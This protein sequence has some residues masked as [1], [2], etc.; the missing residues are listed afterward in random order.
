MYG[1]DWYIIFEMLYTCDYVTIA[2]GY[3]WAVL[4][5]NNL[6]TKILLTL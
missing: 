1:P 4:S 2:A 3:K 6:N 5:E